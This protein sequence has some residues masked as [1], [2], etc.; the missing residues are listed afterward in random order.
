MTPTPRPR[1]EPGLVPAAR[2]LQRSYPG[3]LH[4]RPGVAPVRHGR[5]K[6]QPGGYWQ[7]A[8]ALVSVMG[9]WWTMAY[10]GADDSQYQPTPAT[11]WTILD[12]EQ[13][14]IVGGGGGGPGGFT[15]SQMGHAERLGWFPPIELDT[16]FS[17]GGSTDAIPG[18]PPTPI[19]RYTTSLT[20][21]TV[22][23][24]RSLTREAL[25]SPPD[26]PGVYGVDWGNPDTGVDFLIYSVSFSSWAVWHFTDAGSSG[27]VASDLHLSLVDFQPDPGVDELDPTGLPLDIGTDLL[28]E[29]GGSAHDFDLDLTGVTTDTVGIVLANDFWHGDAISSGATGGDATGDPG[30]NGTAGA[31]LSI[32]TYYVAMDYA[33][34][35]PGGDGVR[36]YR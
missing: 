11:D 8:T 1:H 18:T 13:A 5:W 35:V 34:W 27:T 17:G 23:V 22:M 2:A 29:T 28:V 12:P 16:L 20:L 9:K 6:A 30:P 25:A 19:R 36:T 15:A 24:E 10:T 26:P 33:Y 14:V 32:P 3:M 4:G 7:P 31:L 21:A